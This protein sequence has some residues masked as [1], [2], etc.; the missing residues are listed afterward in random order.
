[1]L[2]TAKTSGR[3]Y[4]STRG[5]MGKFPRR[6]GGP[7]RGGGCAGHPP[8]GGGNPEEDPGKPG[9][10][11]GENRREFLGENRGEFRRE[12]R[13]ENWGEYRGEFLVNF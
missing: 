8:D 2:K 13:G 7:A 10:N 4:F 5:N 6:V 1:M 12:N 11:R 9:G 3:Y